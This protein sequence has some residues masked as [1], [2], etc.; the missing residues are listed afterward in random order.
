MPRLIVLSGLPGVGK[1]EVAREVAA[2]TDALWLRV[3]TVE[4]GILRAG[5]PRSFET[6]LAAYLIIQ[7]LAALRLRAGGDVVVD[8]VNGVEP[9]RE[10][11][12]QL[13]RTT[14]VRLFVFEIV[15]PDPVEH[16]RRVESRT[17]ATPPLPAPTWEDVQRTEYLPWTGVV[18][19]LD[20]RRPPLE[21]AERIV[22]QTR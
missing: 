9:A 4:A 2:Q 19:R 15:C 10:V 3:D 13:G 17:S 5:V 22:R 6:G 12:R 1:S 11:W 20:A 14:D 16:R 8:A 7:D 21:N 18:E